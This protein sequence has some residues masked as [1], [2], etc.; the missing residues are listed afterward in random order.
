MSDRKEPVKKK[1]KN[2]TFIHFF[3]EGPRLKVYVTPNRVR[4]EWF[5]TGTARIWEFKEFCHT[6]WDR[7]YT[8]A[9]KAVLKK[10]SENQ[11]GIPI[12]GKE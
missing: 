2:L 3:E 7:G 4:L 12:S 1:F 5:G 6:I 8:N 10:F 9:C 11:I